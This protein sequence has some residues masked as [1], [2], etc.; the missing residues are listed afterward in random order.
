MSV[1]VQLNGEGSEREGRIS[2]NE[3]AT[4]YEPFSKKRKPRKEIS[5]SER[6]QRV[7]GGKN[8]TERECV[9]NRCEVV[10][11]TRMKIPG[12]FGP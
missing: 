9:S 10:E 1:V 6:A 7:G 12:R 11:G 3:H 5:E 4:A 2:K 8:I